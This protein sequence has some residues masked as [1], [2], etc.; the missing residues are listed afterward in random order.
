MPPTGRLWT[1]SDLQGYFGFASID[2]LIARHPTFPAPLPLGM[3]GRRWL[4]ATILAWVASLEGVAAQP[5]APAATLD[6]DAF[7][8]ELNHG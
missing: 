3:K 5:A 1:T 8:A 6:V 2:E 7:M 4:P